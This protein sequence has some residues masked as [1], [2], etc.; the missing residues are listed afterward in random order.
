[1]LQLYVNQKPSSEEWRKKIY[2]GTIYLWTKLK[3]TQDLGEV[4]E[5]CIKKFLGEKDYLTGYRDWPVEIF[6][7]KAEALKQY[8]TNCQ[9][10]KDII[11][12]FV[13]EIG[14]NPNDYFFDVPRLRVVPNSNYLRAGVSYNYAPHRDTWYGSPG[15]QIN[16]W[17]PIFPIESDQT[18]PIYPSYFSRPIKNSSDQFDVK[19]WNETERPAAVNQVERENRKHPMPK[20]EIDPKTKL[21]LAGGRGDIT[22]FS[23]AH[24]HSSQDNL[25]N[26]IRFSTDFRLYFEPDIKNKLGS[27]L[28]D[29]SSLNKDYFLKSLLKVSDLSRPVLKGE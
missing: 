4:A 26:E 16:T 14:E 15:C 20:E 28:I 5:E 23:G 18:M 21:L 25:K 19:H 17:M 29:D 2:S 22:V 27:A 10:V 24:L 9:E 13:K 8:Y 7:E 11:R 3:S 1:M 12:D 6:I